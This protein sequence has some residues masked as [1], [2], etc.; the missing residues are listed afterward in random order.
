MVKSIVIVGGGSSGWSTAAYMSKFLKDVNIS[1]IESS[2]IPVIGVGESTLPPIVDFMQALGIAEEDWLARCNG[3]IKSAIRFKNF[4]Q[5]G[6]PE[7]WFPFEPVEIVQGRPLSRFWHYKHLTDPA[8]KD[9]F[10]F[11]DYSFLVPEI[12]RLGKTVKSIPG[13]SYAYHVDAGLWGEVLKEVA[14]KHGVIHVVDTIAKV[15]QNED[16]SI[17]SLSRKQGPDL[18]A[19]LFIDCSGFQ[20]LLMEKTLKEPFD[21]YYDYLF[22]NKAVAM[23][24]PYLDKESEMASFTNCHALSSGWAW[25]VPLYNRLGTG[26]VYCGAYKT[27]EEAEQELR[28][29][30]G[31]ERTK[32]CMA[33]HLDIRVGKHHRTWVKNCVAIGLSAGFI[34]PL[35]STGLFIV[36]GAVQLL[37]N[38]LAKNNDYNV[39]DQRAYNDSIT[40]LLEI[41]RD[42]LVCHYSLTEREDTP[43]WRDVKYTTKISDTL[44]EKLQLARL[45]MP[46]VQHINRF[47]NASL[48]G[49]SFNEGWQC[50]LTGMDYLPF[51]W[52]QLK[53]NPAG[54]FDPQ[55]LA[56][57]PVADQRQQQRAQQKLQARQMPSHYQYLKTN[58]YKGEE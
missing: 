8:Y 24:I 14:V 15:N 52:D 17:R 12:C 42:F 9:R 33:K 40:R 11:Y 25:T 31:E 20:S 23:R 18:A 36:Q 19:D 30:L 50:I 26:Y 22:N 6:E 47:D 21:E 5:V 34:E 16:G 57:M 56:N 10:S 58:F 43:Y 37:T 2:D 48:A 53:R 35:E 51:E 29:H 44:S 32:D 45:V 39:A 38:I 41:I 4:H 13:A 3:T 7:I 28:Q 49:F 46:D 54:P 1:L 27:P 55:I